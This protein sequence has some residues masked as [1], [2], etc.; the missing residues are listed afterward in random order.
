MYLERLSLN[1]SSQA[2]H[3]F[4]LRS[5]ENDCIF[6]LGMHQQ[7]LNGMDIFV[8]GMSYKGTTGLWNLS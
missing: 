7:S 3:N 1:P 5:G 2:N 6:L 4:L 8:D